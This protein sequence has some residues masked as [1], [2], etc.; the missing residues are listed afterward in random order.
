MVT[1]PEQITA[2][3]KAA[4]ETLQTLSGV[5][6]SSSERLAALNLSTARTAYEESFASANALL[7]LKD[8]QDAVALQTTLSKPALEKVVAYARAFYDIATE[9]Q[10]EVSALFDAK[11]GELNKAVAVAL[12]NAAKSGPAGSDVAVDAV[13]SA[14][15]AV[16][17]S[18]DSM[19][20]A[21]KDA[22]EMAEANM[23]ATSEAAVKAVGKAVSK[24]AAKGGKK[25]A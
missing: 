11:L 3:N 13:K 4:L 12:E 6:M 16:N 19:S 18:Y 24:P 9:G 20:K 25:A 17:A 23:T 22:M 8:V 7:D 5:L 21:A 1:T 10:K 2:A 14:I 15:A